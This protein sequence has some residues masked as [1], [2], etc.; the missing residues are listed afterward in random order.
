LFFNR[1]LGIKTRNAAVT[2]QGRG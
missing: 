2:P 1:L